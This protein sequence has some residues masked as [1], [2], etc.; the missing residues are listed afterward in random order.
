[1]ASCTAA[2]LDTRSSVVFWVNLSGI[3]ALFYSSRSLYITKV[4]ALLGIIFFFQPWL[5]L[6]H[7]IVQL[8]YRAFFLAVA[9]SFAN[10]LVTSLCLL[11]LALCRSLSRSASV[12]PYLETA[13]DQPLRSFVDMVNRNECFSDFSNQKTAKERWHSLVSRKGYRE[14][15]LLLHPS[16]HGRTGARTL[17]S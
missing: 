9:C 6:I 1:V 11:I 8:Y 3:S 7:S 10:F 5:D 4:T 12:K 13:L 2:Q 17:T 16:L 15:P 14:T